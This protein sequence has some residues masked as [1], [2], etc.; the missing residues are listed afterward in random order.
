MPPTWVPDSALAL[1]PHPDGQTSRDM[2]LREDE[3]PDLLHVAFLLSKGK[4]QKD[5]AEK[6][7]LTQSKVSRLA[8]KA[9]QREILKVQAPLL[10]LDDDEIRDIERDLDHSASLVASLQRRSQ[11]RCRHIEVIYPRSAF[12]QD[13]PSKRIGY[14]REVAAGAAR[15]LVQEML[16]G[17][18]DVGLTW[19]VGLREFC[20]ELATLIEKGPRSSPL[21]KELTFHQCTG[22]TLAATDDPS[23]RAG[24]MVAELNHVL[25]TRG[26]TFSIGAAIPKAF[27]DDMATIRR[28]IASIPGYSAMFR[29]RG[30]SGVAL[31]K[32]LDAIIT[33][34]GDGTKDDSWRDECANAAGIDADSL[35]QMVVGNVG[36]TWIPKSADFEEPVAEINFR[37]NGVSVF[38]LRRTVERGREVILMAAEPTKAACVTRAIELGYVSTVIASFDLVKRMI[39]LV[40][41]RSS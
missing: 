14:V 32:D 19:G 3:D 18:G 38:D 21:N 30:E 41:L 16:S 8:T 20:R 34:C 7:G 11:S 13:T 25:G 33:G 5:I 10:V 22:D 31:K 35:T 9:V 23:R 40:D 6:L 17:L 39:E 4:Q 24:T 26:H 27:D 15:F 37:W 2:I 28:Y 29:L 1:P 12:P 36:G